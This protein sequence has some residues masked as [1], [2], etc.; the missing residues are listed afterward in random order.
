[1]DGKM[2]TTSA[3]HD[4]SSNGCAMLTLVAKRRAVNANISRHAHSSVMTN[5]NRSRTV[6]VTDSKKTSE[7]TVNILSVVCKK[8]IVTHDYK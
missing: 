8:K 7:L 1:M 4:E 6:L 2:S 3:N 5:S